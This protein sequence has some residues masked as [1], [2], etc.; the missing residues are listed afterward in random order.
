MYKNILKTFFLRVD[1]EH[2]EEDDGRQQ[3]CITVEG[4]E[5]TIYDLIYGTL[6][7]RIY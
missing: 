4:L 6:S 2:Q 7:F 5:F 3:S 1:P